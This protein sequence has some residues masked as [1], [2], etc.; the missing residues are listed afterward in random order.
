MN[1]GP[2]NNQGGVVVD[3]RSL[4]ACLDAVAAARFLGWPPYFMS[5]LARVGHLK[6]LGK[7]A[8]NA[9]KWYATVELDRL[10]RDPVWLD[11]AIRIVDRLVREANGKPKG[12][13]P[14][15]PL[16]HL[17]GPIDVLALELGDVALAGAHMPAELVELLPL[18]VFL[19][20][21]NPLMLVELDGAF[22]LVLERRLL[23]A[24]EDHGGQPIHFQGKRL[25]P[26][27]EDVGG[28]GASAQVGL[29]ALEGFG[30]I[31]EGVIDALP[32]EEQAI[33][34][35]HNFQRNRAYLQSRS[36]G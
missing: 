23:A 34:F 30:G 31:V 16:E 20:G 35:F 12:K 10:S 4:P 7:P 22:C 21:D 9:R 5:M 18:R 15:E 25:H 13:E 24:E 2:F 11:K 17:V 32:T 6:P 8:Q 28:H 29:E 3:T 27:Q 14:E 26:A 19:D 36:G 1:Q 33:T